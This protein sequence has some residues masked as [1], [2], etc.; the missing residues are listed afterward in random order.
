MLNRKFRYGAGTAV[1]LVCMAT[2]LSGNLAYA[3]ERV[4]AGPATYSLEQI[5]LKGGESMPHLADVDHDGQIDGCD[6]GCRRREG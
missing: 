1:I 5:S 2:V 6:H 3:G 4:K